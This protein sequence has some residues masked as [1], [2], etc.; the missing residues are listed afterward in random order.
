MIGDDIEGDVEGANDSGLTGVL[1]R[2]GKYLE[3]WEQ[4]S[5]YI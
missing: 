4:R 1:V 3:S 5:D 2:T